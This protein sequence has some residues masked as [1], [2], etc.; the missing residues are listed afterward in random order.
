[1][2]AQ[3][4]GAGVTRGLGRRCGQG[5]NDQADRLRKFRKGQRRI[6]GYPVRVSGYIGVDE[7][8]VR[9]GHHALG[10]L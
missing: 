10:H 1:M 4:A 2:T 8:M 7:G 3:L 5:G 6:Q 9:H